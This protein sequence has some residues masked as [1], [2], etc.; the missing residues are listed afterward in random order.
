MKDQH[1]N[2]EFNSPHLKMAFETIKDSKLTYMDILAE[3]A[4]LYLIEHEGLQEQALR[5]VRAM[6]HNFRQVIIYS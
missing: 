5:D 2:Q 4:E 6:L 1:Q 3:M